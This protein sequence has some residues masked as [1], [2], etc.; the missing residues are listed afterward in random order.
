MLY[1][2]YLKYAEANPQGEKPGQ[3]KGEELDKDKGKGKGTDAKKKG[4]C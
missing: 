4:C 2:D 1:S 3:K